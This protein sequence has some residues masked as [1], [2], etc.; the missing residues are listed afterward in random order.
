M[1]RGPATLNRASR[2]PPATPAARC[3]CCCCSAD[4]ALRARV[5]AVVRL[6]R[7]SFWTA[8]GRTRAASLRGVYEGTIHNV[9]VM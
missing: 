5:G 3:C 1:S 4:R 9:V 8:G 7:A 6:G 2:R